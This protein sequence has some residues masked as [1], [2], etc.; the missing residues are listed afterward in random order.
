MNN[1]KLG[2]LLKKARISKG[3]KQKDVAEL[4]GCTPTVINRL[5]CG[6]TKKPSLKICLKLSVILEL[7]VFRL[8]KLSGYTQEKLDF[9]TKKLYHKVSS[10]KDFPYLLFLLDKLSDNN[11]ETLNQLLAQTINFSNEDKELI[12]A[13]YNAIPKLSSKE[14]EILKLILS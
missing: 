5:E 8:L 12:I 1:N 2:D 11:L 4:I 13:L 14:R 7:D 9:E 10:F 3:L 6:G